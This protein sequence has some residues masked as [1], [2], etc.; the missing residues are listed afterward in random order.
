MKQ[1]RN[2][3]VLLS[4]ALLAFTACSEDNPVGDPS[5]GSI[6]A[7]TY[8]AIGNSL[9][10]GYQS[11]A[12]FESGQIYSYPNLLAQALGS[13]DFQQ[14]LMPHPGTGELRILRALSPAPLIISNGTTQ[15]LPTNV[16]LARPYNNLGI[17]GAI[18]YDA[19][20][21]SSILVRA[22][23]RSNP[24]YMFIMRDQAA[25]GKSMVDQ[26]IALNPTLLTFW[27]GNNDVLG[28]ATSGGVQGTNTGIGGEP[29]GTMPTERAIFQ[30]AIQA[31][32]A[33]IKLTLPNTQ[34]LVANLPSP[35]SVPFFTTVPRSIPNPANPSQMLNIYY[36]NKQGNVGIVGDN[37]YVLLTAQAQLQKGIGLTPGAPLASQYVLDNSEVSVCLQS[38]T[39]FNN[40]L[41]TEAERNGFVYVDMNAFMSEVKENGYNLAGEKFTPAFISGG[42]FSLDGIHLTPRGNAAVAN[43]FIEALNK[44]Y[45]A[46]IRQIPF[47][48][49]PGV[50]APET[51]GTSKRGVRWS[52]DM[53]FPTTYDLSIFGVK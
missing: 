10:A 11:G 38:I 36:R 8:V 37:D 45:A 50:T 34:V 32:F 25:F 30:Q 21:E 4:A 53:Q 2:L 19:I 3:L 9:T 27:L 20:D 17:P 48:N 12:L 15:N 28:Y 1:Y 26:A 7:T 16:T 52:L 22:Q 33:K 31:A 29:A 42:M 13:A 23:Q 49:I 39:D 51:V 47:H 6:N 18:V 24:F 35:L 40:I 41:L 46:N 44:A 14:P 5:L 43:R